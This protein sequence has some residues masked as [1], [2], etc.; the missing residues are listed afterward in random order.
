M[1]FLTQITDS[2]GTMTVAVRE[3]AALQLSGLEDATSFN[4]AF[5]ENSVA[6]SVLASVRVHLTTRTEVGEG[7]AQNPRLSAVLVVAAEQDFLALPTKADDEL[8]AMMRILPP[9]SEVWWPCMLKELYMSP[10]AGL[11]VQSADQKQ[12]CRIA[13]SL[14]ASIKKSDFKAY[15]TGYKITTKGIIDCG[16]LD[17]D[18]VAEP[19]EGHAELVSI[20]T[21]E[22]L[23]QY[24]L[25]PPASGTKKRYAL[26]MITSVSHGADNRN[27][28]YMVERVQ[29]LDIHDVPAVKKM[30]VKLH[31]LA[32]NTKYEGTWGVKGKLPENLL[33]TPQPKKTRR[34]SASPTDGMP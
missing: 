34:L 13:L 9:P 23:A 20:V 7:S 19:T 3:Q 8:R 27:N 33:E 17:A 16:F 2:T 21:I 32:S 22:N 15:G 10:H 30:L 14:V 28:V 26:V 25:D 5:E 18:G 29:Q 4:A 31:T 11:L 24:K 12:G 6:F 1:W